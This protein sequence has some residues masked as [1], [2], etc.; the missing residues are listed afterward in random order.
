MGGLTPQKKKLSSS[1]MS[2]KALKCTVQIQIQA[3]TCP[4]VVLPNQEDIYLSVCV[5]GQFK[6]T[7]CLPPA[8]PLLF[9]ENMVFVKTFT[10][11]ADPGHIVDLLEADTTSF[12]LIQLVPPEGDILATIEE[13]TREFLYPGPKLT[14]RAGG[15]ER[16]MLMRRSICFPGISP[17]VEFATMSVI[18]ECDG[19]DS[20]PQPASPP[21]CRP[22]PDK[23]SP[24]RRR[25]VRGAVGSPRQTLKGKDLSLIGPSSGYEQPTVAS[26]ARALSPYTH[27]RMCQLSEEARQRLSYLQLGPYKFKKETEAQI[28]FVVTSTR[29]VSMIETPSHLSSKISLPHSRSTSFALDPLGD[30][31]LLGSYRPKPVKVGTGCLK[32]QKSPGRSS[33]QD[34]S[35]TTVGMAR[36]ALAAQSS[37]PVCGLSPLLSRSSLR[38]RFHS[39]ESSPSKEIHSRVQK[40]L[41]THSTDRKLHFDEDGCSAKRGPPLSCEDSLCDSQA[42]QD[43]DTAGETSVHLD[44]GT[45]WSSQ[46]ACYTG[47]PHRAVFEDSLRL[48]Y[49]NMYRRA[50]S[51]T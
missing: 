30:V 22:S 5:M 41:H 40:I 3:I 47:K 43:R 11:A 36:S 12:E 7:L 8:F 19:K 38:E 37:T 48:I 32:T 16:E 29:S 34:C 6:K 24:A 26:Q 14:P 15:P 45:F 50:L 23:Q 2:Q 21:C 44:N 20:Q 49:K 25:P 35:R 10:G 9:H 27:R 42:F 39:S 4:G 28:P 46:V 17:K 13:N 18:E 1:K 31:S 33:R 51:T